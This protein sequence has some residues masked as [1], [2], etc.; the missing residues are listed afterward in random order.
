MDETGSASIEEMHSWPASPAAL[1]AGREFLSVAARSPGPVLLVPDGDADGL[2]AGVLVE[3]TL[4]ALGSRSVEFAFL[5]K[6]ENVHTPSFGERVRVADPRYLVVLDTGSRSGAI[7]RGVPTLIV[8][9]HRPT[10]FP[11][12]AVV[13]SAADH[14][15]IAPA[16]LLAW[17]LVR[18]LA[19]LEEW[20]WLGVLGG[21]ADLGS[22]QRQA[23]IE[24]R[25]GKTHLR[26]A[27]ALLNAPRRAAAHDVESALAVLRLAREPADIVKDRVPGTRRLREARAEVQAAVKDAGR[28]APRFAGSAALI[29]IRSAARVHPLLAQRWMRRLH[30]FVVIVANDGY[31]PGRVN[32]SVRSATGRD[33]IAFLREH[34]PEG[35]GTEYANGHAQATGGSLSMEA[36]ADFLAKL[37]FGEPEAP[38]RKGAASP[39]D[40]P[41]RTGFTPDGG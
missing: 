1:A 30:R 6:G 34:A 16:A 39:K 36:F 22:P 12:G 38:R 14:P 5:R 2:C 21:V 3:R 9:H 40:E 4:F 11:S 15:P 37:G 35:A 31:L 24:Q 18:P 32:F 13:V 25:Y 17:E 33:L 41:A 8:D 29:R 26:N 23:A 20:E 28:A 10:G 27:I 19:A 7:A